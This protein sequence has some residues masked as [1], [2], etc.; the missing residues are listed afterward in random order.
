MSSSVSACSLEWFLALS[1]SWLKYPI[2]NSLNH[3]FESGLELWTSSHGVI[4]VRPIRPG[5][6]FSI[7]AAYRTKKYQNSRPTYFSVI[8]ARAIW[9]IVLHVRSYNPFETWR[10]AG[11]AMMLEPFDIIHQRAFPTIDFLSKSD[12][13]LWGRRPA[14]ALNS[15]NADVIDVGNNDYIP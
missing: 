5:T 8:N 4:S 15:Y 2:E 13:N 10:Q 14:Y 6:W 11:G 3:V 1:V 7:M 9:I 12:W